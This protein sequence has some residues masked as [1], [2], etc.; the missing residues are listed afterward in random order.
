MKF[1]I[2]NIFAKFGCPNKL[3]TDNATAF[4]AKELVDMCDSIGIKLVHSTS[5]YPQGNGLG[6]SSNKS[7][8]TTKKSIGKSSFKLVYGTKVVFPIQLTL[9][10]A[11]FLQEEQNEENDMARRMSD[12]VEIHQ[13]KDQLI[14]RFAVNQRKI[15]EAFDRKA[16]MDN[17]QVS[18]W[19]LKW[20][21][22]KENKGNHSKFD[23]MW[24]GPFII[25][26]VQGNNTFVLQSLEGETVFDGLVNGR[27]S[28]IYFV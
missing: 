14:E 5:Y 28:K 10:V 6:K 27:F 8:V 15:K 4:R 9:H 1:L 23:T 18:D 21:A 17:F 12:L 19:V 13:I 22:L 24:I 11:K 26:Q 20:D 7:L 2:E 16:K 3:V 25:S